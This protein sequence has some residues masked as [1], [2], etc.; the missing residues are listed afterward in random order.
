M[1]NCL[2][3]ALACLILGR[4]LLFMQLHNSIRRKGE[5][6]GADTQGV[7]A[8]AIAFG[9]LYSTA[10]LLVMG[11][12]A[13]TS[14]PM[15]NALM[16]AVLFAA[17]L[18]LGGSA[19]KRMTSG[20]REGSHATAIRVPASIHGQCVLSF[21]YN[22]I[23][24]FARRLAVPLIVIEAGNRLGFSENLFAVLGII[25]GLITL[26]S[27]V[28]QRTARAGRRSARRLMIINYFVGVVTWLALIVGIHAMA[29]VP[30][31]HL[32]YL[33]AGLLAVI[34]IAEISAKL[35]TVGFLEDIRQQAQAHGKQDD[36][37]NRHAAYLAVL[38]W[39]KNIGAGA[40]LL[41][42]Y[43]FYAAGI[44]E[45]MA[46]FSAAAMTY[47][48]GFVLLTTRRTGSSRSGEVQLGAARRL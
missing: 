43:L 11:V 44:M 13:D 36:T 2:A 47:G 26:L 30:E 23:C 27:L 34:L 16:A 10:N 45:T 19:R 37:A 20:V 1:A 21:L 35:W 24:Y 18:H 39:N 31:R 22:A 28:G 14:M 46:I 3:I 29:S 25:V 32:Y 12:I 42:G 7:L 40:G 15:A 9:I 5:V 8:C 41:A 33:I 4:D 17:T 38:I 6:Y 48:I